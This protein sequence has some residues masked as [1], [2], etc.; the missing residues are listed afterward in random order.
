M[1][2]SIMNVDGHWTSEYA[3]MLEARRLK[4]V[5]AT[6]LI[7][8]NTGEYQEMYDVH[9]GDYFLPMDRAIEEA[10]KSDLDRYM[11]EFIGSEEPA[12]D[13]EYFDW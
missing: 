4:L 2:Y 3:A 13:D 1:Y 6:V 8:D 12:S 10:F 9:V 11:V 5:W 7:Y